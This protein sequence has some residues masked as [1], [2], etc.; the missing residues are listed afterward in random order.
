[1]LLIAQ[2]SANACQSGIVSLLQKG[3]LQAH[4]RQVL[5][6]LDLHSN[7]V[8]LCLHKA[9]L[10]ASLPPVPFTLCSREG[11]LWRI[12][13]PYPLSANF[14]FIISLLYHPWVGK[15][16]RGSAVCCGECG[17]GLIHWV[18]YSAYLI[19][20][21]QKTWC[22]RSNS[23]K[24]LFFSNE[25]PRRFIPA[26]IFKVER[27]NLLLYLKKNLVNCHNWQVVQCAGTTKTIQWTL[28][29]Y[30]KYFMLFF[31]SKLL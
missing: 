31:S 30:A 29:N 13:H 24:N 12:S 6:L 21:W 15:R 2:V 23:N 7:A 3:S 8:W 11:K 19:S 17:V 28:L 16:G 20:I 25:V 27:I 5:T 9:S 10:M 14:T 26:Y 18:V 22:G 4:L 1:M